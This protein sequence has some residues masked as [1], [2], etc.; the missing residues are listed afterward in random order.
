MFGDFYREREY[1]YLIACMSKRN[2]MAPKP[3]NPV[4]VDCI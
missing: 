1:V 3:S 4:K 2:S